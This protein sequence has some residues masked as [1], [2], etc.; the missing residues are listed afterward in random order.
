MGN[1]I[2]SLVIPY[3]NHPDFLNFQ[4][5]IWNNYSDEVKDKIEII[6][7][8]DCSEISI[9]DLPNLPKF[10]ENLKIYRIL[11]DIPWNEKGA[12]NLGATA[13]TADW[14]LHTDFDHWFDDENLKK[15]IALKKDN[16]HLYRF[17]RLK[18]GEKYK[19]HKESHLISTKKFFKIGGFDE[20]FSGSWGGAAYCLYFNMLKRR[21]STKTINLS[22]VFINAAF[23]DQ[24]SDCQVKSLAKD[25]SILM[26]KLRLKKEKNYRPG[27]ILRFSWERLL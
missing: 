27:K 14:L 22:N 5:N 8:D 20:D 3:Y 23:L 2:I 15:L 13:A 17:E 1:S 6:L 19:Q 4:L 25:S 26:H 18:N 11:E 9:I 16:N 12:R 7:V 21:E 24:Y 10:P